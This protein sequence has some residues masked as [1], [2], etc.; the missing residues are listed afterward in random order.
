[1][2]N[3]LISVIIPT[4]NRSKKVI[5]AIES[6]L[7]QDYEPVEVLVID[8]GSTDD[9]Q[10]VIAEKYG[11][12]ARVCYFKKKNGGV[13]AARNFGLREARG[14]FLAFLDADDTWRAGKLR[15]QA[16]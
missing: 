16:E 5:H 12:D 15:L 3:S 8:D 2:K 4:Y 7:A 13:A 9:T 10:K 6:V 11:S 1:M 14:E